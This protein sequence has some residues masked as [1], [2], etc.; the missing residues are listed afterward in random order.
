MKKIVLYAF[1]LILGIAFVQACGTDETDIEERDQQ[2]IEDSLAQAQQ[3]ERE[4][5]RRDNL[6]QARA[7]SIAVEEERRRVEFSDDGE[8]VVQV[9]A[10]RSQNKAERQAQEWKDNGYDKASVVMHGNDDTGDVWYRVRLGQ[11]DTRDMANRL[12]NILS[13]DYNAQAWV[14][15]R[16]QSVE[17]EAT[18]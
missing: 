16:G 14:S 1:T 2:A 5:M 10:W 6:E 7:D 3:A 13:E 11:F 9:E 12:Q 18:Q 4:Q 15:R 17:P 8:Y